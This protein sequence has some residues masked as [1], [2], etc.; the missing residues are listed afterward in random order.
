MRERR[1]VWPGAQSVLWVKK[2]IPGNTCIG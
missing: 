1:V 2:A